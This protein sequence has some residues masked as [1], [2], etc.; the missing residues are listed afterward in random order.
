LFRV[1]KQYEKAYLFLD[2]LSTAPRP[3]QNVLLRIILNR[4]IGRWKFNPGLR[5]I[6]ASNF[7]D[8]TGNSLLSAAMANRF[9]HIFHRAEVEEWINAASGIKVEFKEEGGWES[10]ISDYLAF[11]FSFVETQH[12]YLYKVPELFEKPEDYAFCTPRSLTTAARLLAVTENNPDLSKELL[13]GTIGSL[14]TA[15][16]YRWMGSQGKYVKFTDLDLDNF[17]FPD[18]PSIVMVLLKSAALYASM[19]QH[20]EKAI[21]LFNKAYAESFKQMVLKHSKLLAGNLSKH[22]DDNSIIKSL[23][24]V[25][26]VLNPRRIR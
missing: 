14:A 18:D 10:K 13:K 9:V 4:A 6:A 16:F 20:Y 19:P 1:L 2:E 3:T 21:A 25:G 12:E 7:T 17:R 26:Q 5:V 23:P 11:M 22:M 24:F 8:V 15:A